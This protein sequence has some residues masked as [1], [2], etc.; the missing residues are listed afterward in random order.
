MRFCGLEIEEMDSQRI[1]RKIRF[2]LNGW[3]R[4]PALKFIG[5]RGGPM[6]SMKLCGDDC[7]M[8][9]SMGGRGDNAVL[10]AKAECERVL[11]NNW[12]VVLV[13]NGVSV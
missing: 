8:Q 3:R 9:G 5:K 2:F 12:A 10:G 7:G 13:V 1:L 4:R 11:A 6:P